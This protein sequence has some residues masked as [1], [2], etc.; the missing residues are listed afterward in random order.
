MELHK[1]FNFVVGRYGDNLVSYTP[2]AVKN[3]GMWDEN[4]A[5]TVYKEADYW[6]R[7]LI[8]NK[9][10]SF[11]N[12]TLHGLELNNENP[13]ELDTTEDRNFLLEG[14]NVGNDILKRKSDD[15]EHQEIWSAGRGGIYKT[16]AWKY[17]Y[18]KWRGTWEKEPEKIGWIKEWS[19]D[20][21]NNPPDITKSNVKIYVKYLYFEK[22]IRNLQFKNYLV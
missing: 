20:F 11:I 22:S 12:D 1:K 10:K 17:F 18:E 9:E 14:N 2:D 3:I 4:F 13:L 21:I 7:A 19:K 6:I 15:V 8:F 5:S 16:F